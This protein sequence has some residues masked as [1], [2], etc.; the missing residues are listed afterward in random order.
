MRVSKIVFR[1]TSPSSGNTKNLLVGLS[2]FNNH[3]S[4]ADGDYKD[5]RNYFFALP[6]GE[7]E[8]VSY[9]NR[10]DNDWDYTAD[11]V[12]HLENQLDFRLYLDNQPFTPNAGE[13]VLLELEFQL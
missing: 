1:P 2:G 4:V 13:E 8:F 12:R 9:V 7:G 6:I 10:Q 11:G 3:V 5:H